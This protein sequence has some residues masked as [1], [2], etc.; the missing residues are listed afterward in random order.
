[1]FMVA[2]QAEGIHQYKN[3]KNSLVKTDILLF[4]IN[5][6]CGAGNNVNNFLQEFNNFKSTAHNAFTVYAVKATDHQK[7]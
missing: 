6:S 7:Q 5:H 1:M 3:V 4:N 2:G